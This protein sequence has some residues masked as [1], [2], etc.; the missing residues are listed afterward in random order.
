MSEEQQVNF[1][2]LAEVGKVAL[3]DLETGE[4]ILR[5]PSAAREIIRLNHGRYQK[6]RPSDADVKAWRNGAATRPA[7]VQQDA[8]RPLAGE[9]GAPLQPYQNALLDPPTGHTLIG[10][11]A[12]AIERMDP[13]TEFT[14]EGFP[15]RRKLAGHLPFAVNNVSVEDMQAAMEVVL[16]KLAAAQGAAPEPEGEGPEVE[17]VTP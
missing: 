3:Y 11:I 14:K 12:D 1:Q 7:P 9:P 6:T 5:F 8:P 15:D 16:A 4:T 2:E 10:H 17:T 13:K